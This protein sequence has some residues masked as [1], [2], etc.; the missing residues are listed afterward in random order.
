VDLSRTSVPMDY[1]TRLRQ[2]TLLYAVSP[3]LRIALGVENREHHDLLGFDPVQHEVREALHDCATN[4]VQH[5]LVEIWSLG[6][7]VE[8]FLYS[9]REVGPKSRALVF[10]PVEGFIEFSA[11]L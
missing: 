11:S 1:R 8:H 5:A 6:D 10:V 3:D 2:T 7:P 4:T 9:S